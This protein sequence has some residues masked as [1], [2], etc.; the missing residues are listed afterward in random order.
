MKLSQTALCDQQRHVGVR[1]ALCCRATTDGQPKGRCWGM[2]GPRLRPCRHRGCGVGQ[3]SPWGQQVLRP[4]CSTVQGCWVREMNHIRR[5]VVV[6][7]LAARS[8]A[9]RVTLAGAHDP[10][11]AACPAACPA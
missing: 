4:D 6:Q 11:T 1:I 8:A 10:T 7:C 5:R 2:Q 9:L 3:G